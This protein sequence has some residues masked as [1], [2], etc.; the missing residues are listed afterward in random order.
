MG[1]DWATIEQNTTKIVPNALQRFG[2][3]DE[4]CR[5]GGLPVQPIRP[6]KNIRVTRVKVALNVAVRQ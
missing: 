1:D 4:N 2:R 3:L 5:C 6:S